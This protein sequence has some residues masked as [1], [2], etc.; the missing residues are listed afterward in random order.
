LKCKD[1]E[2]FNSFS[3]YGLDISKWRNL[4]MADKYVVDRRWMLVVAVSTLVIISVAVL[5]WWSCP[6]TTVLVLR[7]AEKATESNDDSVPLSTAGDTRAQTFA[8]VA[9]R[10]G[11]TAIYVTQALRTQQT[12]QYLA[13]NLGLTPTPLSSVDDLITEVQA[14]KNRGGVIVIVGH[15]NT[16]PEIVSRLNG[17]TV[18]VGPNEFDNL[19]VLTIP[20]WGTTRLVQATYGAPR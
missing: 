8:Q 5:Y 3:D 14:S 11:V 6:R 19:F 18:T 1:D 4:I 12:A 13:T 20:R 7:H 2:H 17:G 10:A 16:V 15:S 9:G